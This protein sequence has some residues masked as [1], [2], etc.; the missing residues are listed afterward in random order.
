MGGRIAVYYAKD[1]VEELRRS[2][3]L[4]IFGAGVTALG[5]A[6]SLQEKPYEFHIEYCL[7]SDLN[8]NPVS[9]AGIPVIDYTMAENLVRKGAT[10]LV[11]AVEKNI[12][13]MQESLKEHGYVHTIPI[14]YDGDLWSLLRGNLYQEYCHSQGKPYLTI[15]EELQY[16]HEPKMSDERT[17]SVYTVKCHVDKSL[18]EDVSRFSWEKEI[19]AGAALADARICGI[20]DDRGENIS[21]KNSQYCELTALYWIWKHGQ[22][23]YIGLGHYRRHFELTEDQLK[24]LAVS[25]IDVVLTIPMFVFPNVAEVYRRDHAGE[26][27]DMMCKAVRVLCPKYLPALKIIEGAPFYYAYNMFIMRREILD[28]YCSWLFPILGYCEERCQKKENS[29]QNRYIGF[30]AER[31]L[32]VYF[33]YHEKE[34]KI[35]HARKHFIEE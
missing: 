18:K 16:I 28:D 15:E 2:D 31:L 1:I 25:D 34:Y 30:L 20:C 33:L 3:Q 29:Y 8:V 22:S 17:V 14:T 27:W 19:Q 32:S 23:D 13:S 4:V 9:V 6:M 26:D 11:A 5:V 35:V 12:K 7:V 21:D 24:K 10:I